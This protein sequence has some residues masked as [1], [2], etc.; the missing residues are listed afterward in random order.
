MVIIAYLQ[1][2]RHSFLRFVYHVGG[3]NIRHC[4]I[5]QI[6]ALRGNSFVFSHC[7]SAAIRIIANSLQMY[8]ALFFRGNYANTRTPDIVYCNGFCKGCKSQNQFVDVKKKVAYNNNKRTTVNNNASC[9]L[10]FYSHGIIPSYNSWRSYFFL[11]WCTRLT[12]NTT[13]FLI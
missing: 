2:E 13:N 6:L 12:N 7:S 8:R 4:Y 5:Y 1:A 11:L 3:C 9:S 10:K